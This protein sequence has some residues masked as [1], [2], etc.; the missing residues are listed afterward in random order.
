MSH[1]MV[2]R[3]P[4]NLWQVGNWRVYNDLCSMRLCLYS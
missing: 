1:D 4:R 3:D 2:M